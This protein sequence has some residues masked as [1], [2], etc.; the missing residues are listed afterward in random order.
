LGRPPARGARVQHDSTIN[1]GET[2][3]T[4]CVPGAETAIA[5]DAKFEQY[6]FNPESQRG[7]PKGDYFR[8]VGFNESNWPDLREQI[9]TQLPQVEG[10]FNRENGVGGQNW[11]AAM[12]VTGPTGMATILTTWT[13]MPN[14]PTA[15]IGVTPLKPKKRRLWGILSP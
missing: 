13:V 7:A 5:V 2:T 8:R 9:L 3:T 4:N 12:Q 1:E 6:L 10:R 14:A 15:F 11:E